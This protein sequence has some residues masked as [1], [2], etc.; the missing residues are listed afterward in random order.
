MYVCG[1]KVGDKCQSPSEV[2]Y[3]PDNHTIFLCATF[4]DDDRRDSL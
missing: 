2:R 1:L 4:G 3:Y